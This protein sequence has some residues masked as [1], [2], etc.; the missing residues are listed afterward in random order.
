MKI[1]NDFC[2]LNYLN[3]CLHFLLLSEFLLHLTI[4]LEKKF[5][6]EQLIMSKYKKVLG[7]AH[8][9]DRVLGKELYES[10]FTLGAGCFSVK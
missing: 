6:T 1:L 4:R 10:Y 5:K 3:I 7:T 9:L 2:F 8:I